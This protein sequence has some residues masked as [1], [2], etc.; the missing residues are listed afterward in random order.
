MLDTA[1]AYGDSETTL[2]DIGVDE[3]QIITKLP[4]LPDDLVDV[5]QWVMHQVRESLA[6]LR[7]GSVDGLLLHRPDQLLAKSGQ[8]LYRSLITL[9]ESG[10]VKKIGISIYAPNELDALPKAMRFDIVQAP[11][12]ILDQ[13]MLLSGWADRLASMGTEFHAR[14]VFLQGLLL[15]CKNERPT[16]FN[17]WASLWDTWH[18]WLENH[19]LSPISASLDFAL[20][21]AQISKVIIGVNTLAQLRETLG[22]IRTNLPALPHDLITNDTTLLNPALWS[23]S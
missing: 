8:A 3:W 23:Q 13:R 20:N 11:F 1:I 12:N 6:R 17:R 19:H 15:M 4:G 7:V 10:V 14:S 21:T 16:Q 22:S 5:Q 9:R 2:G 18:A